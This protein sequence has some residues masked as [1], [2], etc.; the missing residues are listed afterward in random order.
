MINDT[1]LEMIRLRATAMANADDAKV[2][3]WYADLMEDRRV[4]CQ[5]KGTCW[6]VAVD[7]RQMANDPSFD[8]A[9]RAAYRLSRATSAL[10]AAR[11]A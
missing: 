10:A 6:T 1:Q 3:R 5:R 9:V 11:A 2:W 8:S 7:G 4:V